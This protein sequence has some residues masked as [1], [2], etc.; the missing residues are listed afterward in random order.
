MIPT[1][2]PVGDRSG[3]EMTSVS[4]LYLRR[5]RLFWIGSGLLALAVAA[6][7]I[8]PAGAGR[9]QASA[10]TDAPAAAGCG[11][12][13][14]R[15]TTADGHHSLTVADGP[16]GAEV[17]TPSSASGTTSPTRGR[18]ARPRSRPIRAARCA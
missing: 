2:G 15:E 10:L 12:C 8:A 13:P 3:G 9:P 1:S 17:F 14:G 5:P 11:G 4:R 7:A 6:S 16:A 18:P